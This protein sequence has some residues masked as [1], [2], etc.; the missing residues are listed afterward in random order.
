MNESKPI[1][2]FGEFQLNVK[3]KQLRRIDGETVSLPPKTF[4]LLAVLV[5]NHGRLLTKNELLD[6]VWVD[7]FVEEGNLK[8]NIHSLRKILP[9]AFIETVPKHGYRFAGEVRELNQINFRQNINAKNIS[10]QQTAIPTVI[11][12]QSVINQQTVILS[13][14]AAHTVAD[15]LTKQIRKQTIVYLTATFLLVGIIGVSAYYILRTPPADT[16]QISTIPTVSTSSLAV[17]PFRNLTKDKQDEFLSVGLT[18]SLITKLGTV[19]R[20]SVRPVSA[21]L[22]FGEA[23]NLQTVSENLQVENVLEGSIQRLDNRLKISVQLVQ[24]PSN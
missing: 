23:R 4:E 21:V 14:E 7:S 5:E 10:V 12:G 19:N 6:K 13:N 20:L 17:L 1:Y 22:P 16:N 3:E 15:S 11:D 18:D 8:I 2:E 24:M 9:A